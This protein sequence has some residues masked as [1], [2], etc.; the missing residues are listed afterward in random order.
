V[1]GE[2]R[3][4]DQVGVPGAR[5]AGRA[6][7]EVLVVH[8]VEPDLDAARL[9]RLPPGRGDVD[10]LV[11]GESAGCLVV[12]VA[13]SFPGGDCGFSDCVASGDN[14]GKETKLPARRRSARH[15]GEAY[16]E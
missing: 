6:G 14:S 16:A 3:V 10:D 4:R 1:E 7:D 15:D 13:G 2:L 8:P 12:H 9:P 11:G 5:S